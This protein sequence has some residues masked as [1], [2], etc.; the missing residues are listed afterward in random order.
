MSGSRTKERF[1]FP[2]F[3]SL[4]TA[5]AV[6]SPVTAAAFGGR[7]SAPRR[8]QAESAKAAIKTPARAARTTVERSKSPTA[9]SSD[10]LSLIYHSRFSKA[11]IKSSSPVRP[12][13]PRLRLLGQLREPA[14]RLAPDID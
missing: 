5:A 7:S 9:H 14:P 12:T 11:C 3:G 1:G 6:S 10:A 4:A 2:A 8:P 13:L